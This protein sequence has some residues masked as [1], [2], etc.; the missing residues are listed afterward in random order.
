MSKL[1][2]RYPE[3]FRILNWGGDG[4]C[5]F[6]SFVCLELTRNRYGKG[7]DNLSI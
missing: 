3:V 4:M 2:E 7:L 6:H 1:Q 5:A